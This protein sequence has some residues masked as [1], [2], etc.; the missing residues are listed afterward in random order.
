[1]TYEGYI[2]LANITDPAQKCGMELQIQEFGQT[3][4]QIFFRPHPHKYSFQKLTPGVGIPAE[5]EGKEEEKE[6]IPKGILVIFDRVMGRQEAHAGSLTSL[7]I[8]EGD[9]MVITTSKDGKIKLFSIND[10][11][12]PQKR[13]YHIVDPGI[14]CSAI[15]HQAK[16]V[17]VNIY[18]YICI[19]LI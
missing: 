1:M 5:E 16:A 3:P 11:K 15:L 8:L 10:H 14:S 13:A 19:Y 18:I 17:A 9:A 4:K 2:D 6:V 7:Q 12:T